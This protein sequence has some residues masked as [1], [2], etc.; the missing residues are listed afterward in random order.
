VT[1]ELGTTDQ[2]NQVGYI[3]Y[4]GD[5]LNK[6]SDQEVLNTAYAGN[7]S[8]NSAMEVQD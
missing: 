4:E 3:N 7:R 8:F 2:P 1:Y 6:A 5:W